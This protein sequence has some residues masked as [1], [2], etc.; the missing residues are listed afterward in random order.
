MW[1]LINAI[2]ALIKCQGHRLVVS[3]WKSNNFVSIMNSPDDLSVQYLTYQWN[4]TV[5]LLSCR[6]FIMIGFGLIEINFYSWH[7]KQTDAK[8]TWL[9]TRSLTE[10]QEERAVR[11][12]TAHVEK[13]GLW[14]FLLFIPL[15]RFE[16]SFLKF[17]SSNPPFPQ[18]EAL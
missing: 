13:S 5:S 14:W 18:P 3:I 9:L 1:D 12:L 6:F 15:K 7:Q 4:I 17:L 8:L 16:T 10:G 11:N 2:L